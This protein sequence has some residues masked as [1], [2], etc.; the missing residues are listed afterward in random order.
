MFDDRHHTPESLL[1]KRNSPSSYNSFLHDIILETLHFL[2]MS[3]SIMSTRGS[4][5]VKWGYLMLSPWPRWWWEEL[6]EPVD[7]SVS[8]GIFV[9]VSTCTK[10]LG[11]RVVS[12]FGHLLFLFLWEMPQDW[13]EPFAVN[14]F[15]S[16]CLALTGLSGCLV[17]VRGINKCI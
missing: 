12:L 10:A 9:H 1:L 7:F 6:A 16:P 11:T 8:E 2:A 17:N 3:W 14:L 15:Y 13:P 4:L 5:K